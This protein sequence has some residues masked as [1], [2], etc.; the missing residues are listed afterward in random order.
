MTGAMPS[1]EAH[2]GA[3]IAQSAIERKQKSKADATLATTSTYSSQQI[4][5]GDDKKYRNFLTKD[6][7]RLAEIKL[8]NIM[9]F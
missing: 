4:P 2:S 3:S 1:Y 9:I 5:K 6:L 8:I 7:S